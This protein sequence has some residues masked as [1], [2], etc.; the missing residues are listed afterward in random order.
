MFSGIVEETGIVKTIERTRDLIRLKIQA[1]KSHQGTKIGE[2]IALDGV[3]VTVTHRHKG[4]F[5]VDVMKETM[6]K[7]TLGNLKPGDK[8]NLERALQ[9]HARLDGHL[10]QG[11][12]EGV[13]TI[14]GKI[15]QKNFIVYKIKVSPS[16]IRYIV[17]K[18]SVCVDGISLTV[19]EVGKET[20]SIYLIPHTMKVTTIGQK[21]NG[22]KVN[23]ETDII[24]RYIERLVRPGKRS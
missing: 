9:Y 1:R 13:G 10:V 8:V 17:P 3:C 20:F 6:D 12:V 22:D 4:L 23:I 5:C 16:L 24:A 11:H 14:S 21:S 7:T 18:G 15:H 19:G 2:S